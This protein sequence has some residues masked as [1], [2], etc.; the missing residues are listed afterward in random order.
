MAGQAQ[1]TCYDV[2]CLGEIVCQLVTRSTSQ[3]TLADQAVTNRYSVQSVTRL[4]CG[5]ILYSRECPK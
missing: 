5:N 4:Y 1:P 3:D 2:E